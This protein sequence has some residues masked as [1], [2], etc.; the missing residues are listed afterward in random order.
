MKGFDLLHLK[1]A[2]KD[3]NRFPELSRTHETS[4][5][6]GQINVLFNEELVP[7]DEFPIKGKYFARTSPL[8]KPTFGRV[9]FKTVT[10]FV[11]YHQ[12]AEDAEAFIAGKKAWM[13]QTPVLRYITAD[14]IAA[15][16]V[17]NYGYAT[18]IGASANNYDI[19]YLYTDGTPRYLVFTNK[20]RYLNKILN[21]LGYFIPENF[22]LQAG[23][24]WMTTGKNKKF[25]AYAF[26]AFFKGY[27]DWMSQSQRYNVSQLS[28]A[29]LNIRQNKAFT[30]YTNNGHLD[31]QVIDLFFKNL[32][33]NYDN[34]YFTSAWQNSN[35][36]LVAAENIDTPTFPS[37]FGNFL[38]SPIGTHGSFPIN[39]AGTVTTLDQR[40]LNILKA[41]D[42]W[43]RRNN[44]A[45]SRDVQQIYARFGI[46][47]D[48]YRTHYAH[49]IETTEQYMNVGDVT[50]TAETTGVPLGD[51]AGKAIVDCGTNSNYKSSD[52]GLLMIL[53]YITVKPQ[54]AFG[55]D[56]KNLR[57]EP[58]DWYN[59]EFDGVGGD[60]ITYREIF[61][62][63]KID[64][65]TDLSNGDN[66]FGFTERYNSYRFGRDQITGDFKVFK[67]MDV[68]HCGRDLSALRAGGTLIAQS[69]SMNTL[70][71]SDSE[72]NRIFSV[73]NG[74]VDHFYFICQFEV[75]AIRPMLSLSQV[76]ELGTGDTEVPRNGNVIN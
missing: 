63:C 25:S 29:L 6:I 24:Y 23:S 59:P 69:S 57:T 42:D 58:L 54:M 75:N 46:K 15:V 65:S 41:F 32:L 35:A 61:E 64:P 43:V 47:V 27:N 1:S 10:M 62:S 31:H 73:Q 20:G 11:P 56:R 60:P 33:L 19:I 48:D 18:T 44:Y 45:G 74:D 7:S 30:G 12:I 2:V 38:N 70:A 3:R 68:W 28:Y 34:D 72:Y 39:T 22:D 16:F 4:M 21:Q 71:Q 40:G 55:F 52:Y 49:V 9:L 51:Y 50:A 37:T 13:G 17:N 14:D 36:P 5:D 76:P 66:V 26:L 67:D 8:V 53:G